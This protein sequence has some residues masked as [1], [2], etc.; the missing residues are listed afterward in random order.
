MRRPALL[1]REEVLDALNSTETQLE[2]AQKLFV[3]H[4]TL[5]FY[6]QKYEIEIVSVKK[7]YK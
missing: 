2:A 6:K 5:R 4:E 7:I 3:S 1:T